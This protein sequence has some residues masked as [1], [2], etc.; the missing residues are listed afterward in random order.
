MRIRV[1]AAVTAIGFG[2]VFGTA[3]AAVNRQDSHALAR[4]LYQQLI[5]IKTTESGA[6]STPAAEAMAQR[7]REG[8]FAAEDIHIVGPGGRKQNLVVRLKGTGRKRPVLLL[9]HL[10]V[11]EALRED[12]TVDPFV[13]LEKDGYFYGR[14]TQDMKDGIAV[15]VTTLLRYRA[16][17]FRPDRDIILALT[18]DEEGGTA[19]GVDWLLKNRRDLVD[20]EFVLNHDGG[21]VTLEN[22]R[23]VQVDL[24]ASEKVYADFDLIVTNPGGHSSAPPRENAIYSLTRALD[25]VASHDFAFEL[26]NVTRAYIEHTAKHADAAHA[27]VLRGV[28]R[29]PPDAHALEQLS[30]DPIYNAVVR[31]TCV[32]TRLYGGHANNALPQTARANVNCRILPGHSPEEV[33]QELVRVIADPTVKVRYYNFVTEQF[34]DIAPDVRGYAPPPLRPDV[35]KPLERIAAK[36]WPGAAVVPAMAVGASDSVYTNAA[37]LPTY[38][39]SGSAL[40]R[41]DFRAHGQDERLGVKSFYDS[42]DF[43][44]E[45]L[46]AVVSYR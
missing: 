21:G 42:V 7:L 13:F 6:G 8:G 45:F 22:G 25:R 20:A 40:P 16:E 35:I 23:A 34:E 38:M 28:L 5:E 43:Y 31:T 17:G 29:S 30:Q 9:G 46:K 14:G 11:V 10:D 36:M 19:N 33:R 39:V 44:Y 2:L 26:N 32:A 15:M 4:A 24:T 3:A 18:A 37:G 1:G 41:D 12:W 27:S